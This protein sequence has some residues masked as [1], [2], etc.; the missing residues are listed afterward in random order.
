MKR[1]VLL[2]AALMPLRAQ[3]APRPNRVAWFEILPEPLADGRNAVTLEATSQFLRPDRA[4]SPDGRTHADLDA[5]EWQL[6]FDGAM[7]LGPGRLSLRLRVVNRS[8]GFADQAFSSWHAALGTVEGGR[9]LSPKYR[10]IYLLQR[11]G[12]TVARLDHPVTQL[13]DADLAWVRSFGDR[14]AGT[15][16]GLA[17]Q[18]PNGRL[19]DWSGNGGTDLLLGGAAWKAFGAWRVHGQAEQVWIGLPKDSPLRAVMPL[20]H[21]ARA[22]AGL[23]W[24][25]ED[26]GFWGGLGLDLTLAYAESPYRVGLSRVDR[27]G[28][29]QHWTLTHRA[30]PGWFFA[31][32][33]EAGTYTAPDLTLALGFR[34]GG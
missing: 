23:G 18:L 34:F 31:L 28:W 20:H 3:D 1:L 8:G 6:T 25:G 19:R 9:E 29:Q 14:G 24:Q 7:D 17:L 16:W 33:E 27:S 32:S 30:L 10:D 2:V 5:E 11:D 22:W 21:Q 13:L 15:R 26:S 12:V 4:D